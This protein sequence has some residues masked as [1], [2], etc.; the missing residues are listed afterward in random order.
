MTIYTTGHRNPQGLAFDADGRLWSTE[1]G[2]EGGDELNLL[3]RGG[4][5]GYP[6]H[7]FGTDYGSVTWPPARQATG[8][9]DPTRPV[10]AW[11]PSIGISEVIAVRDTAFSRWRNDLLVASLRGMAVWRI[12]IE[13][14]RV[15]YAEPIEIGERVRDIAA[16]GRGEFVLWTD[17][18]T[19]VRLTPA[20]AM[21]QGSVLF[22]VRCSGCHD[23]DEHRI[24]PHLGGVFG[25][26]VASA[27]GYDYSSSLLGLGGRWTAERLDAYLADPSSFVPGTTM[28]FDGV[29]E[30]RSRSLIIDYLRS[31]D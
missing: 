18:E 28:A 25:G 19:I 26:T 16:A 12:R 22:A 3:V 15:I 31:L 21:D 14:E 8:S 20:T 23:D 7:T 13:G 1:H 29:P 2:P 10:F 11:I 24:G 9:A 30:L 6:D 5:Y 27:A 4:N 17:A